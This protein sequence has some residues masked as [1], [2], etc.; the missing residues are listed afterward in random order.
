MSHGSS[1]AAIAEAVRSIMM[2]E[3]MEH[4]H[5][6]PNT[7]NINHIEEQLAKACGAVRT[8]SWKVQHVCLPIALS[9]SALARATNVMLTSS[10]LPL[11]YKINKEIN[12]I[13]S[14]F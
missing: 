8:T 2:A 14:A 13:T 4:L 10:D 11:P 5:G 3:N 6:H 1:T 12:D 7:K 9:D